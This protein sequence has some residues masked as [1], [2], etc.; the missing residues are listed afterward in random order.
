MITILRFPQPVITDKA[1]CRLAAIVHNDVAPGLDD[2][3]SE[4]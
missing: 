4:V 2:T 3:L 1:C